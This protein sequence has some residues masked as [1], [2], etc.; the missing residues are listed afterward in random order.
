MGGGGSDGPEGSGGGSEQ[1]AVDFALVVQRQ[2][3]QLCRQGEDDVEIGDRQQILA[4]VLQPLGALPRLTLGTRRPARSAPRRLETLDD[5]LVT[6]ELGDASAEVYLIATNSA[7]YPMD[8]NVERLDLMEAAA[9][10]LRAASTEE[11]QPQARPAMTER[12][13][14]RPWVTEFNNN[15]PLGSRVGVNKRSARLLQEAEPVT[16]EGAGRHGRRHL[17]LPRSRR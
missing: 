14:E 6:L 1:Q 15:P 8:P 11:Y 2:R 12:A 13:A 9:K 3:R 17:C 7:H 4:A 10:G 5:A 16:E